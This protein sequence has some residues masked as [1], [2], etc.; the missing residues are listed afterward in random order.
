MPGGRG[1]LKFRFDRRI[2]AETSTSH[3][4]NLSLS[5]PQTEDIKSVKSRE[6]VKFCEHLE[7][8][9]D[10]LTPLTTVRSLY[11]RAR[12]EATGH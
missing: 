12:K 2:S 4:R 5:I 10:Y 3:G 9:S 8:S 11:L 6:K 1:M 7:K